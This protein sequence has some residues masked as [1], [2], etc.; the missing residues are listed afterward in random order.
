VQVSLGRQVVLA[1]NLVQNGQ[2]VGKPATAPSDAE[3]QVVR[4]LFDRPERVAALT[5]PLD[6]PERAFVRDQSRLGASPADLSRRIFEARLMAF[7]SMSQ[8][9]LPALAKVADA[10][11]LRPMLSALSDPKR[12]AWAKS[13]SEAISAY[14]TRLIFEDPFQH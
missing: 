11:G 4:R 14:Q 3:R 9:V 10:A 13:V 2:G 12:I 6:P 1:A 5:R 7:D 8:G